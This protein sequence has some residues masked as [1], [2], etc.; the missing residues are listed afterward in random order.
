MNQL[1]TRQPGF[2]L[3]ENHYIEEEL[4]GYTR[5]FYYELI[6]SE[7]ISI[8]PNTC[9][10]YIWNVDKQELYCFQ[11]IKQRIEFECVGEHLIGIHLDSLYLCEHDEQ[12]IIEWMKELARHFSFLERKKY[13]NDELQKQ[14]HIE[15][16]HPLVRHVVEEIEEA[17]GK[18]V[19]E[20]IA[21]EW[22]Y[23]PR[24]ME[25]LFVQTFSYGPKR[26]CQYIR[27][28]HAI[29]NMVH[30]PEMNISFQIENLGDSDQAHFQREF[31]AVTGVT[32]NQFAIQFLPKKLQ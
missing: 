1:V 2:L 32:P 19:I 31:K 6:L 14:L 12:Q 9:T 26:F 3:A 5:S 7:K 20:S 11:K 16:V 18:V 30:E 8:L 13:C 10:E 23:T 4:W 25:R 21:A 17:R 28:L 29:S 27:L 22:G 15:V 24:H